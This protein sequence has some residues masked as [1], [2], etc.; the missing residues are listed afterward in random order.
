[1]PGGLKIHWQVYLMEFFGIAGFVFIAGSLTIFLEHPD[2]PIMQSFLKDHNILRRIP[3]A[4]V[5]GAYI[6]FLI[7]LFGKKSGAHI[8]PSFTWTLYRLGK[9]SLRDAMFFSIAQFSGAIFSAQLLKMIMGKLF[10]HPDINYGNTEPKPPYST[11]NAF[12]SE[13]IISFIFSFVI[14]RV[15][16]SKQFDKYGALISGLLIA[17]YLIFE[18]PFSGMSLNPARSLAG[19]LAADSWHHLWLY[20]VAPTLAM[21]AAGEM[22]LIWKKRR[23]AN[24]PDRPEYKGD[25]YKEIPHYPIPDEQTAAHI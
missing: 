11:A 12:V 21:L 6:S 22:Y 23:T 14:L 19:A 17:V 8:S 16:S 13:F 3:L 20:F 18:I 5:L 25:D 2:F 7:I 15:G 10:A 24:K 4:I 1:M 9:I